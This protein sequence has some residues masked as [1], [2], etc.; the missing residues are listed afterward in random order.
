ME[1]HTPEQL[2]SAARLSCIVAETARTLITRN[3]S[4]CRS[5]MVIDAV[6]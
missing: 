2:K 4:G 5:M 1:K 3:L 6:K